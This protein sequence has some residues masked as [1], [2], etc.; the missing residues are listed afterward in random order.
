[1][2][3][4]KDTDG[5]LFRL[6][7][8]VW[9]GVIPALDDLRFH[10]CDKE[11][12]SCLH[13]L[14]GSCLSVQLIGQLNLK[15]GDGWVGERE[16]QMQR[17]AHPVLRSHDHRQPYGLNRKQF[18]VCGGKIASGLAD[19]LQRCSWAPTTIASCANGADEPD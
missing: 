18:F 8:P 5:E 3:C 10:F 14:G 15:Q 19:G 17:L 2:A 13:A 4:E 11:F 9:I 1:M 6:T 16:A 12:G 7:I